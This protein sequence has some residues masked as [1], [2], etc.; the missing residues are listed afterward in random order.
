MPISAAAKRLTY[1]LK[2]YGNPPKLPPNLKDKE[3]K[4]IKWQY[5]IMTQ[6]GIP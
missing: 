3:G 1:E 6:L 2:D 4:D 5:E